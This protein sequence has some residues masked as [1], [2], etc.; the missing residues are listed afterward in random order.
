[1]LRARVPERERET[2]PGIEA[3]AGQ[4]RAGQQV[5]QRGRGDGVKRAVI[6]VHIYI[7]SI[8]NT[9]R[10]KTPQNHSLFRWILYFAIACSGF[11][12]RIINGPVEKQR[13]S[14][15]C[16]ALCNTYLGTNKLASIVVYEAT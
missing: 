5:G 10:D 13:A 7:R 8:P 3:K 15:L 9:R 4:G 12:F 16:R 2:D 14:C 11:Y 1:M 6:Y